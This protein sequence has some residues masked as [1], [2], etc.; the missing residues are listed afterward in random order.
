MMLHYASEISHVRLPNFPIDCR[1]PEP[2][3]TEDAAELNEASWGPF[4]TAD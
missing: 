1:S 3:A 4:S 2:K